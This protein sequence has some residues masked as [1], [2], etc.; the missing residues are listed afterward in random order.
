PSVLAPPRH[1][2]PTRRSSDLDVGTL[3]SSSAVTATVEALSA[4]IES[5]RPEF[6]DRTWVPHRPPRP[7]KSEGGVPLR[8]ISDLSPKGDQPRSEEH[9]SELQSRS[10][11]VCRL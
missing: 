10:D 3:P 1:S 5:G 8:L 11:L 6:R 2:F 4:L 7:E 9:T